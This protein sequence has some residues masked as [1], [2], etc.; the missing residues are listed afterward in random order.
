MLKHRGK[1]K[2]HSRA[3]LAL[4]SPVGRAV[5]LREL[6]RE[7]L[8]IGLA[9]LVVEHGSEQRQLLSRPALMLGIG[10]EV[11]SQTP[12]AGNN[13]AG[14]HQSLAEVVRMVCDG[15]RWDEAWAAQLQLAL[16]VSAELMM[17]HSALAARVL[18]GA[19]ALQED[20]KAGRMQADAIVPFEGVDP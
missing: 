2:R 5:V 7:M 10:A 19:L 16:E 13:R 18:P 3:D 6:K 8:N 15:C 20:I 9:C 14:L 12:V 4:T 1:T 17:E 11:A